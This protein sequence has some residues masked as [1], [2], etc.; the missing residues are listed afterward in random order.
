MGNSRKPIRRGS[1]GPDMASIPQIKDDF[2]RIQLVN[3]ELMIAVFSKNVLDP[4]QIGKATGDIAK[5]ANRLL[6]NLA[7]PK[8]A[9]ESKKPSTAENNNDIRLML[10]KL[11]AAVMSFVG[12]PIFQVDRQVVNTQLAMKVSQDLTTVVKLSESIRRQAEA[13]GK[14]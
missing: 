10:S 4:K 11:D 8:P 3:N 13:L 9:E 14:R 7:Y 12:N 6:N 5:R 2:E 1:W